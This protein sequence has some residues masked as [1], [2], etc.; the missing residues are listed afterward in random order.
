MTAVDVPAA[1][2]SFIDTT[3]RG[4]SDAFAA[5]FTEDAHLYDSSATDLTV[6]ASGTAPTTSVC[7]P[8]SS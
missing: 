6:F 7:R 2:G 8:T 3:N 5:A 4:D 1:I